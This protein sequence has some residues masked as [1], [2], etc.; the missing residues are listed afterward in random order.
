MSGVVSIHANGRNSG[1]TGFVQRFLKGSPKRTHQIH[2]F[3]AGSHDVLRHLAVRDYL[4]GHP[5]ECLA[6]AQVK[7]KAAADCGND[8]HRYVALKGDFVSPLEV[9]AL[10][11]RAG[12]SRL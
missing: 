12:R 2:A 4:R 1:C 6:Y 3:A 5:D 11:E 9:R 7:L 10:A 8:I